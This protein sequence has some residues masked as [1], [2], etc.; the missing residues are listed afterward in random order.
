MRFL[1]PWLPAAALLAFAPASAFAETLADALAAAYVK[2]PTLQAARADARSADETFVQ[3]RAGFLPQLTAFGQ[4]GTQRVQSKSPSSTLC[5]AVP[6]TAGCVTRPGDYGAEV[7]ETIFAGG[8][9]IGQVAQANATIGAAHESLRSTEQ[10][11]L[12]DAIAA[13]MD[14][15]RDAEVL[16]IRANNVDVLMHQL[17]ESNARFSVGEITKTDVAQ[18]QARLSGARAALSQARA[19]LEA[20]RARYTQVIG[21]PPGQL[22]EPPAAPALPA[23]LGEAVEQALD[24]NPDYRQFEEAAKAAKAQ[25][26]IDRAGLLPELSVVGR[27]DRH[28][29][30]RL[31]IGDLDEGTATAQLSIPLYSGGLARSQVRQSREDYER[32]RQ[33][34]EQARREVVSAVSD[35]WNALD[36]ARQTIVS[37]REQ[38]QANELAFEGAEQERQVGLRTTIEVLNAQQELLDSRVALVR[39][40]RDAYIAAHALLQAIGALN[41]KTLAVNAPLYD[42]DK[43]RRAVQWRF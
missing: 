27:F 37:S 39:A 8:R 43:H 26:T 12:L 17:E 40:E 28:F 30:D 7:S 13:Y 14:V 34:A 19:D 3:A 32:A 20:S 41:A 38:V 9:R 5:S 18:S 22:E 35:A 11:V 36:A 21:A 6:T 33:E 29:E 24:A 42:P 25:I 2:N 15:R 16:S 31:P 1:Q 23:S 4:Y 10:G